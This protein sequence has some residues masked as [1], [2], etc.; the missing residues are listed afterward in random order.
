MANETSRRA[1]R[2]TAHEEAPANRAALDALDRLQGSVRA[3]KIDLRRWERD[4]EAERRSVP[5]R[6]NPR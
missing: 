6:A 2:A 4:V 3:R 5:P 1:I